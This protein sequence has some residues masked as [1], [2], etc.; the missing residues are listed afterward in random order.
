MKELDILGSR[1]STPADFRDVVALLASGRYP[2]DDTVTRTVSF[3]EAG[4]ALA[5]W[6]ANPAVITKIH[7][8]M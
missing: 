6:S 3:A 4:Q 7:V 2:L 5:D 1:N 8:D